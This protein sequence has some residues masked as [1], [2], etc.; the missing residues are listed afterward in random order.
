MSLVIERSPSIVVALDE[1]AIRNL[2]LIVLNG[3]YEGG[4]TGETF[5]AAGK[6]DILVRAGD[7]NV[8]IAECKFWRGPAEFGEAID[9]LFGYLSWR[10]TKCALLVFNQTKDSTR[11]RTR[12]FEVMAARPEH[13]QTRS[14][15]PDGDAQYVLV[16]ADD[17]GREIIV[18]TMLF[19]MPA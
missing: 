1:E 3:H 18:T 2:F 13:R 12:M 8:F 11:V 6:T 19:D 17:P 9:Q 7:R 15:A 16:K 14:H 5:N 4:A 10:D